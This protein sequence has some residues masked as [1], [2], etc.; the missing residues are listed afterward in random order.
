MPEQPEAPIGATLAPV[1]RNACG[2][3]LSEIGWFRVDW[4][5]GGALTGYATYQD[6]R[7]GNVPVVVKLPVP[8]VERIWLQRLQAFPDLVPRLYEHG[9]ALNGYDMVWIV[10]E[11]LPFGPLGTTWG[12]HQFDLLAEAAGR[13]YAAASTFPVDGDQ[14]KIDWLSILKRVRDRIQNGHVG[15]LQRWKKALKEANRKL[16]GWLAEWENLGANHWCHGDLHL[17]NALTR[18]PAPNGPAVLIDFALTRA[19]HWVEDA[20]YF[21]HLFW[22]HRDL[23]KGRNLCSLV[24]KQRKLHDLSVDDDWPRL[25]AIRRALL[26]LSTP[27][28]PLFMND[29]QQLEAGLQVLEIALK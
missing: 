15:H 28:T 3:R 23:L 8:P 5:R 2:G 6:D 11:R 17:A 12:G 21:E 26:A 19:G 29:S 14:M 13:F 7:D 16:S 18:Q 27:V 4:Q 24:A 25:A 1:L 22:T 20:V 9:T 10:M